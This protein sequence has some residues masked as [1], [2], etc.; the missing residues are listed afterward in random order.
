MHCS[1]CR[2][3]AGPALNCEVCL[4]NYSRQGLDLCLP[5]TPHVGCALVS[6]R[7]S[8]WTPIGRC[9]AEDVRRPAAGESPGRRAAPPGSVASA[10]RAAPTARLDGHRMT[11]HDDRPQPRRCVGTRVD[12]LPAHWDASESPPA[13]DEHSLRIRDTTEPRNANPLVFDTPHRTLVKNTPP[14]DEEHGRRNAF[15]NYFNL[16]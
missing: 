10:R 14:P 16:T 7:H 15:P 1:H 3:L 6:I 11:A 9:L 2:R 5:R 13:T 12:S 4:P 8:S